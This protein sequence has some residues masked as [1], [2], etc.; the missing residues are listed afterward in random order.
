MAHA[1]ADVWT[2]KMQDKAVQKHNVTHN[3]NLLKQ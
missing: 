1:K 2:T 3:N